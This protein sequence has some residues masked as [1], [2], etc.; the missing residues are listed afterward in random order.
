VD[1][2]PSSAL[3][4]LPDLPEGF[5][6]VESMPGEGLC[7]FR[8]ADLA[9]NGARGTFQNNGGKVVV[10]HVVLRFSGAA[11]QAFDAF[12]NTV[13]T[14]PRTSTDTHELTVTKVP[15]PQLDAD[16]VVGVEI[17]S[18]K[19]RPP[20]RA[21]TIV[22]R[23]GR[24]IFSVTTARTDKLP[25]AGTVAIANRALERLKAAQGGAL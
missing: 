11:P 7:G 21:L 18:A 2:K 16:Q 5:F 14:C 8:L 12:E 3:V 10:E 4:G 22:A 23:Q 24:E 17:S 19:G 25:S 20:V 9:D 13:D 15:V 6:E 1:F